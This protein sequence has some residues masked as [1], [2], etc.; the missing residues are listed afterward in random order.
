MN[1]S[2]VYGNQSKIDSLKRALTEVSND[3]IRYEINLN[4]ALQLEATD[5]DSAMMYYNNCID[6]ADTNNWTAKKAQAFI[7]IGYAYMYSKHSKDAGEFLLEGLKYYTLAN[8]S[9]GIMRSYYNLGYFYGTFEDFPKA[10]ENFREAEEYAIGLNH[11]KLLA[12]IYNNLGLMY[13]YVGQY[14]MANNYHFKSLQ[15]SEKNGVKAVGNTHLNI[16]LNYYKEGNLEKSIEHHFKALA[17]FKE[18]GEKP[19]IA[20]ALKNIGDDYFGHNLDSA[21]R[22]Y[23]EAHLI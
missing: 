13:N 18:N 20:L 12:S 7:N 9:L 5:F 10:I 6:I 1:Y 2:L 19:Y 16:G 4:I 22:Y 23:N 14:D 8:D 11:E 15:L 21:L 17:I 3:S